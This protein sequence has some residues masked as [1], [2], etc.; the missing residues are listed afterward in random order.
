M[1]AHTFFFY[2]SDLVPSEPVV[3]LTDDEHFHLSRV[4]RAEPGELVRV[5]NGRGLVVS[6]EIE[7]VGAKRTRAHVALVEADR[8]EPLPLVLALGL[9]PHAHMDAALTQCIEAGITGFVPVISE[10]SH[11]RRKVERHDPRWTRLSIA[12]IK[13]CGRAWLPQLEASVD[14]RE[15]VKRFESFERVVI[16]DQDAAD[17]IDIAAE[18]AATLALVG[19][20]GGFTKAE[21]ERFI[22]A[23]AQPVRLSA[24]RLRAETAALA[25]VAM[26]AANRAP[27]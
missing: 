5:T 11:V 26:L 12:A 14:A 15:L 19:P 27:V 1:P 24:H 17:M 23:G 9:M 13:Q 4:L 3:W 8:P 21:Q 10:R 6:A 22:A 16:A 2:S 18:P 7:S 20:E 25:L